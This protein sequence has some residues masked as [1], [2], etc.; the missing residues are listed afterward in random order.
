MF[1]EFLKYVDVN[2]MR[3][4]LDQIYF[5]MYGMKICFYCRYMKEWIFEEFGV[6]LFMYY[7]FVNDEINLEFFGQFVQLIG[8]IGVFVIV[9]IYNG[10][11][12]V[13]FEGEFNV[14]VIFE[15]VVIVMNVNGVIF[16]I[17]GEWYFLVWDN[18]RLEMFIDVFQMIFVEY[19]SV[20]VQSVLIKL[21][22]NL[23]G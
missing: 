23:M 2:G 1:I 15:I 13:I 21:K 12:Q 6:D 7:E 16:F 11:I 8:I 9:I 22:F 5:Y 10:I 4:Y 20:D 19:E 3:I 17:G 18:L 14:F